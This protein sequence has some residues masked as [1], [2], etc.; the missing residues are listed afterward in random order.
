MIFLH[1]ILRF[2]LVGGDARQLS[3][4]SLL[5]ADGHIISDIALSDAPLDLSPLS[6]ADCIVLPMPAES[7]KGFIY[8]PYSSTPLSS[9]ALLDALLPGQVVIG[10]KIDP[11]FLGTA[12]KQGLVLRDYL[13]REEFAIANAVPT[14]EG[15]LQL[16]MEHLPITIHQSKILITGFGR[17]GQCTALRFKSLGADV[18]VCARSFGQL[19]S[20]ES[21]GC[22]CLPLSCLDCRS[23]TWDL[24]INTVPS[25]IFT[26][27]CLKQ[28][29]S[30]VL[31][32]LASPPGGFVPS[33]VHEL[34]LQ[35]ISA[36]G[37]PGKVAPVTAARIVQKTIYRMLEELDL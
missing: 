34:N 7:G 11:H 16:A 20:A 30:P 36:S 27:S 22:R 23:E 12:T 9:S 24:I 29:G 13:P 4:H 26:H 1:S 19:A 32:E 3:L 35:L 5:S 21:M 6:T 25:P 14:A 15:A 10:G 28:V 8:T 31:M 33:A 18:T 37:L 2:C 17:V